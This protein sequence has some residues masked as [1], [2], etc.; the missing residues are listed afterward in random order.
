MAVGISKKRKGKGVSTISSH[1]NSRS[2]SSRR[3]HHSYTTVNSTGVRES[4]RESLNSAA[5]QRRQG[6]DHE[7]QRTRLENMP[8]TEFQELESMRTGQDPLDD[9][10][11]PDHQL[12]INDILSGGVT[13]DVSHAGGEF[14]DLLADNWVDTKWVIFPLPFY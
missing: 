11:E 7:Q 12:D 9:T 1:G 5:I 13:A 2:S 10:W 14:T 3:V 8:T 6:F 4:Q